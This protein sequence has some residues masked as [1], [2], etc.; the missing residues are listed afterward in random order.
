MQGDWRVPHAG[1]P[2]RQGTARAPSYSPGVS[3]P[4]PAAPPLPMLSA[5][6]PTLY[7]V[8]GYP[9][10][11]P[12]IPRYSPPE[13]GV[14]GY[15]AALQRMNDTKA[16]CVQWLRA[17]V[18]V[19]MA[20]ASFVIWAT[21]S[22][23]E[24]KCGALLDWM[25]ASGIVALVLALGAALTSMGIFLFLFGPSLAEDSPRCIQKAAAVLT[26]VAALWGAAWIVATL[27]AL[28]RN[29]RSDCR[30]LFDASVGMVG[31]NAAVLLLALLCA[32]SVRTSVQSCD[33]VPAGPPPLGTAG[34]PRRGV[35]TPRLPPGVPVVHPPAAAPQQ[36]P[37]QAVARAGLACGG[38]EAF[39]VPAQP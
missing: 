5:S 33:E 10:D 32:F 24:G 31:A 11:D 2:A 18:F 37:P 20:V 22:P 30:T 16:N 35:T 28:R 17:A 25:F 13:G 21:A 8:D 34:A 6:A 7:A 38:Q 12:A 3:Q 27:S 39:W 9:A 26:V 23:R 15:A 19:S 1:P 29:D 4:L 36:L 14:L